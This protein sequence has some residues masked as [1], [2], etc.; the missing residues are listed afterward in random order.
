MFQ[1]LFLSIVRLF[2]DIKGAGVIKKVI[3]SLN[4]LIFHEG[5]NTVT[6][7]DISSTLDNLSMHRSDAININS[8]FYSILLQQLIY[9]N[10][11][12]ACMYTFIGDSSAGSCLYHFTLLDQHEKSLLL[13]LC[14]QFFDKKNSPEC[15]FEVVGDRIVNIIL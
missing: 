12:F 2:Q 11:R 10:K 8:R 13:A 14:S 4:M 3:L 5:K 6:L 1:L 9:R 15:E 7:Y